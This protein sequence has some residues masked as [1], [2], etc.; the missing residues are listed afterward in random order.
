M[1]AVI[2]E[3]GERQLRSWQ[4]GQCFSDGSGSPHPDSPRPQARVCMICP[5]NAWGSALSPR[6]YKIKAC[7]ELL[8]VLYVDVGALGEK[9]K[10]ISITPSSLSAFNAY[11]KQLV[12]RGIKIETVVTGMDKVDRGYHF[13]FLG[14]LT[15]EEKR[16]V[17]CATG[18][19]DWRAE[20][21]GFVGED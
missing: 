13:R 21:F 6:G 12:Q 19:D 5:K 17:L 8:P 18:E 14:S 7:R 2:L 15:P 4:N 9:V 1:R 16:R 10:R 20:D 3:V 11:R